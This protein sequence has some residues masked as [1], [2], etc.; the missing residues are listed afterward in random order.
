MNTVALAQ[1]GREWARESRL[2]A[3]RERGPRLDP[4]QLARSQRCSTGE[5]VALPGVSTQNA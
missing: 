4:D 5:V 2:K 1:A 3:A